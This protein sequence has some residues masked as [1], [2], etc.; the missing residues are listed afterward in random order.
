MLKKITAGL[1]L[2]V[3][4]LFSCRNLADDDTYSSEV[5]KV[6]EEVSAETLTKKT[7]DIYLIKDG[8]LKYEKGV[9][10]LFF[11][12]GGDIPYVEVASFIN[13]WYGDYKAT[14][15]DTIYKIINKYNTGFY[16]SIDFATGRVFYSNFDKTFTPAYA[17]TSTDLIIDTTVIH[18]TAMVDIPGPNTEISVNLKD[19]NIPLIY[20]NDLGFIPANTLLMLLGTSLEFLYNGQAVF[21]DNNS[22]FRNVSPAAGYSSLGSKY[23][24]TMHSPKDEYT[25]A[26]SEYSC[27]HLA[28]ALDL[29]YGRKKYLGVSDFKAWLNSSG[30]EEGLCSTDVITA[31]ET[32]SDFLLKNIGDLHT[33]FHHLTPFYKDLYNSQTLGKILYPQI[34]FPNASKN[35]SDVRFNNNDEYLKNLWEK[36]TTSSCYKK[37][38]DE[39]LPMNI[40]IPAKGS[41]ATANTIFLFFNNFESSETYA[42]YKKDWKYADLGSKNVSE[43]MSFYS[44]TGTDGVLEPVSSMSLSDFV[45]YV[46][47]GS[48]GWGISFSNSNDTIL[49]TVV[50]NYIIQELNNEA[51]P[52]RKI[53][54]VVLDLSLNGGGA[55]DDET[56]MS[57]WFLGQSN[58]H[59]V[60]N[61]TGSASSIAY[62]ADV[63]F[64][65]N[66]NTINQYADYSITKDESKINDS[67]DTICNLNR[68]CITSLYSFSCG[69]IF[70]AQICFA[71]T[72]RTFGQ[73][74]GGGTCAVKNIMM[75]S[76]TYF[77]TSSQWQFSTLINGSYV[78]IDNGAPVD[79]SITPMEFSDVYDRTI[80]CIKY[81]ADYAPTTTTP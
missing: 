74:S 70:P 6:Q 67:D 36:E 57:S 54:N 66:Y 11:T 53:D 4:T 34:N 21:L 48:N 71:D 58:W 12:P 25:Q 56:F 41:D 81:L 52:A 62:F 17:A 1:L 77:S 47:T 9:F 8:E 51:T 69:N 49:L 29:F 3:L 27:S 55:C 68:F 75:P 23:S 33:Y 24:Q 30:V 2:L 32:L 7:T 63:D 79:T 46:K 38:A 35:P 22:N 39:V 13:V 26:F 50:A 80:F 20:E 45:T 10:E 40:F 31:E 60:N 28:L 19:Y 42:S 78:D 15:E 18:R 44:T 5:K 16:I 61:I 43:Y 14:K 65:D 59:I 64:D 76:G 72:V 73:R 37:S